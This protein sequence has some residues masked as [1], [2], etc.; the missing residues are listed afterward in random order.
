[1]RFLC[2]LFSGKPPKDVMATLGYSKQNRVEFIR[3]TLCLYLIAS[4]LRTF[5]I[6]I[7]VANRYLYLKVIVSFTITNSKCEQLVGVVRT[8]STIQVIQCNFCTEL[9]VVHRHHLELCHDVG[10]CTAQAERH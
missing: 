3:F 8:D 2:N 5:Q 6:T 7:P 10:S 9:L 1:M 4:H